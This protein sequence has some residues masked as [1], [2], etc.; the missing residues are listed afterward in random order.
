MVIV[1]SGGSS[2]IGQAT[3]GLF[4]KKG[5]NVYELSRSGRSVESITHLDCDI[6]V[7]EQVETAIGQIVAKEGQIDLLL[8]NAGFGIAGAFTETPLRDAIRQY[9][10]NVFGAIDFVCKAKDALLASAN[11]GRRPRV[12]FMSSVAGEISIPYQ[13]HY[14]ATKA[15]LRSYALALDNEWRRDGIRALALLPGDVSTGFTEARIKHGSDAT[16]KKS[17]S[18]MEKDEI[19]GMSPERIAKR[20]Y[21][22]L[23]EKK[24]PKVISTVGL[25]YR[26]ALIAFRILPVRLANF[27]IGKL[28]AAK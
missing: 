18:R 22:L 21:R 26:F 27:V 25:F 1:I 13:A 8:V 12:L 9:E 23:V 4:A 6:T 16:A 10:V 2:G 20:V 28:Y 11:A 24:N 14:S 17:I 7:P 15:A 3:A 5:H 19:G